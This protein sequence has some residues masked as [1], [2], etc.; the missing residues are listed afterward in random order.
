MFRERVRGAAQAL[1]ILQLCSP[2]LSL[3]TLG[4]SSA[5][6]PLSHTSDSCVSK[7][8]MQETTRLEEL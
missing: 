7:F 1:M 2:L 6:C 5:C 3:A 8:T 4:L